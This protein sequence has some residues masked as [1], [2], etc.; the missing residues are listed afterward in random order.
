MQRA[1]N[2]Q[3]NSAENYEAGKPTLPD[4]KNYYIAA[5]IKTVKHWH[6]DTQVDPWRRIESR[7][8]PAKY[9]Q[10]IFDKG[11]LGCKSN[12]VEKG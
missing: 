4:F 6:K 1:W 9:K 10:L 2:S 7:N 11:A 3:N 5:V 8:K 12:A